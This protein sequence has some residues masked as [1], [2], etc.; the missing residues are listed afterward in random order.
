M[1]KEVEKK[2]LVE[3]KHQ[4]KKELEDGLPMPR[5]TFLDLY[6]FWNKR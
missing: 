2:F 1:E 6:D 3:Y 5:V 4:Q